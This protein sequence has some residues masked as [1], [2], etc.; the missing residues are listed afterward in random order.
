MTEQEARERAAVVAEARRWLGTPY[1]HQARVKGRRGGVDCAQLLVGVFA[2]VG[3]ID[4]PAIEHYPPD[5]H[6]HRAAER[7]LGAVLAHA[8][9]IDP[10]TGSGPLP[11]DIVLWRFGRCFSHGA[12]VVDWPQVIHAY[13]GR[14]CALEDAQKAVWL[15]Q[16]GEGGGAGNRP[17]PRRFF[18][19]WGRER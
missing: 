9:E 17:R 1:H 12:I 10:S 6:L 7:Y 19:Y 8:R 16:I 15:N 13:L 5:W 14:P 3:L 4:P 18:S 2:A 11:G